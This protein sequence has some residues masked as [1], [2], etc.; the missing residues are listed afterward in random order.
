MLDWKSLTSMSD[1]EL[2]TCDVAATNL[3][4]AAGLPDAD[5]I[6]VEACI[7]RLDYMAQYTDRFGSPR[8]G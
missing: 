4:C 7:H 3:A 6:D 2:T 1:E 5:R 8:R